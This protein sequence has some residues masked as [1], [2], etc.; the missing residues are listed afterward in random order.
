MTS[1]LVVRLLA[2]L[3]ATA[4]HEERAHLAG[5]LACY[6]A[7]TGEFERAE[8]VKR[9]LRR[10]HGDGHNIRVS[11]LIMIAEALLLYYRELSPDARDRMARASLLSKAAH[12]PKLLALTSA[13]MAHIDFNQNR[14]DSMVTGISECLNSLDSDDGAAECRVSLVLGDAFL[15]SGATQTS[16]FW[17]ERARRSAVRIGDQAAVGAMTYNRAALRVA[18][19][20]FNRVCNPAIKLDLAMLRMD[21]ESAI[22]YQHVARIRSLDHLLTTAKIGSLLLQELYADAEPLIRELLL[23]NDVRPGSAQQIVLSADMALILSKTGKKDAAMGCLSQISRPMIALLDAD[24]RALTLFSL[25]EAAA[26]CGQVDLCH[27]FGSDIAGA[28][29]EH[30]ALLTSIREKIVQFEALAP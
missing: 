2:E 17:Y 21:V 24:D 1:P 8:N 30:E 10:T 3:D 15:F 19:S 28:V 20:R 12:V 16:N 18:T 4:D 11:I 23:S 13:W 22:N 29:S 5:E 27:G 25:S 9:D 7:R 26:G 6:W 14:F